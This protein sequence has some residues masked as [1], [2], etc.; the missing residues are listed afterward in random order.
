MEVSW[1][2]LVV[3]IEAFRIYGDFQVLVSLPGLYK[4]F[5]N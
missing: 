3:R 1:V 2:L 5:W 4:E